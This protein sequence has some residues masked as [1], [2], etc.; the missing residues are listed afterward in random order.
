MPTQGPHEAFHEG[1]LLCRLGAHMTLFTCSLH[2]LSLLLLFESVNALP[3]A[4]DFSMRRQ[5]FEGKS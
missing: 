3:F 1:V 4:L 2:S 5:L